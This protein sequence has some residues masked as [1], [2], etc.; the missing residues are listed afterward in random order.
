MRAR[1]VN[2]HI[3]EYTVKISAGDNLIYLQALRIGWAQSPRDIMSYDWTHQLCTAKFMEFD[4]ASMVC[5][6]L[7]SKYPASLVSDD[8]VVVYNVLR[9]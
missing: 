2:K 1:H 7:Q 6:Q 8:E 4:K 5:R 3:R 9:E